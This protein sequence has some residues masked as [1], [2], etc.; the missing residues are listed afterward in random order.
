MSLLYLR[1]VFL[2]IAPLPRAP[3]WQ[4]PFIWAFSYAVIFN[5]I[6]RVLCIITRSNKR[7][8]A[9]RHQTPSI[10]TLAALYYNV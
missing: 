8:G 7:S 2:I 9:K 1:A 5:A 6:K 10:W 3:V 4:Y